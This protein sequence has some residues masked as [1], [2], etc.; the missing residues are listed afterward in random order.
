VAGKAPQPVPLPELREAL[1][2]SRIQARYQPVVRMADRLPVG[3]EALARLKHPLR[4]TLAPDLFIPQMEAAGLGWPLTQAVV[5]RA[6]GDWGGG[7]L[8]TL[9]LSLAL[10][11]PLDVLLM[12]EALTWLDG[13]C[14]LAEVPQDHVIIELT[15]SRPVTRLD[16]L[17]AA[18]SR[19]RAAGYG[20][21]IDDVGPDIRDHRA[22][23]DLAFSTLKL[24]KELVRASASCATAR[25]FLLQ[26]LATARAAQLVTVAEGIETDEMWTRMAELGVEQAQGFLIARPMPPDDVLVWH[27]AWCAR[28]LPEP[29]TAVA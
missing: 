21:A 3:L 25:D 27:R 18:V 15:E 8:A 11:F 29:P 23:L 9:G 16:E 14:A 24:D 6:F 2:A 7:R 22:L 10:N 1:A 19:L 20:M 28:Y 12:P 26:T 4:G 17:R 5:R 13:Q